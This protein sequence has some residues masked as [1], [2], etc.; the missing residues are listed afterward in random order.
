TPSCLRAD[1]S[2]N[3][4]TLTRVVGNQAE[5]DIIVRELISRPV[6][7]TGRCTYLFNAKYNGEEAI[8]KFSWTP[9][10]RLPEGA[11]YEALV[12][13]GISNMPLIFASGILIR[14]LFGY[15]LE[16]LVMEHCG[17][18]IVEYIQSKLR[19]YTRSP[20]I[21][22]KATL[23]VEQVTQ[24]LTEALEIGILHRDIS[25]GNI[26]IKG[27]KA[28]V[29][30]WGYSKFLRQPG[31]D[32]FAEVVATRWDFDWVKVLK[33]ESTKDPFTGT[34]LYMSCRLLLEAKERGIYDDFES[35]LYVMLDAFSKRPR[36]SS[37]GEQPAGFQFF[38]S[39]TTA[40]TRISAT[41]DATCFLG[42]FGVWLEDSLVPREMLEA[43]RQFLFVDNGNHIGAKILTKG[44][45]HRMFDY[46]AAKGFMSEATISKLVGLVGENVAQSPLP[47]NTATPA[48][49]ERV[50]ACTPVS[51][52]PTEPTLDLA[53]HNT[54]DGGNIVDVGTSRNFS[55]L[56]LGTGA[57]PVSPSPA[58]RKNPL[59]RDE[60]RCSLQSPLRKMS[61]PLAFNPGVEDPKGKRVDTTINDADDLAMETESD[62]TQGSSGS[63]SPS[64]GKVG[65][66]GSKKAIPLGA[67]P[68]LTRS[69]SK[70]SQSRSN[71]AAKENDAPAT[72][73]PD[74]SNM[75]AKGTKRV[76]RANA[77]SSTRK[78]AKRAKH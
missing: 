5:T 14:D 62:P 35:L 32:E 75:Q 56:K 39:E 17:T 23:Y 10:N 65:S 72:N 55:K 22:A 40:L 29:I 48:S 30:D 19:G 71:S 33:T 59:V 52:L 31:D 24:T 3:Q 69:R 7:I 46:G 12:K 36:T 1:T 4:A 13:G 18:P 76:S 74:N 15:R 60:A 64:G 16:F 68:V 54:G 57:F 27:G 63:T 11:V 50:L 73:V 42:F 41:L 70:L 20:Q 45:S 26:A 66:K 37:L 67:S 77:N 25:A 78:P 53:Q 8:L 43:M 34:P 58:A 21:T 49:R 2:T 9:T 28:Y 44:D 6:R 61:R 47:L 38:G 51:V